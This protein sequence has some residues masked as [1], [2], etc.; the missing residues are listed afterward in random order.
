MVRNGGG[1]GGGVGIRS[2]VGGGERDGGGGG[3]ERG[4]GRYLNRMTANSQR[5]I[6]FL[7]TRIS[8]QGGINVQC[9]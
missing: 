8:L 2:R 7:D 6:K 9:E 5:L 1:G 4:N 3:G